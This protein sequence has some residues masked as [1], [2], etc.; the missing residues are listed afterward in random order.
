MGHSKWQILPK[1]SFC[2][3]WKEISINWVPIGDPN[4]HLIS[5]PQILIGDPKI[6][7]GGPIFSLR[8]QMFNG[9]AFYQ[10]PMTSQLSRIKIWWSPMNRLGSPMKI[11]GT[12]M[13]ILGTPMKILGLQ[14]RVCG[15]RLISWVPNENLGDSNENLGDSIKNLRP[16]VKSLGSPKKNLESSMKTGKFWGSPIKRL[17]SSLKIW[18]SPMRWLLWSPILL[19][20]CW[21]LPELYLT[22]IIK[23][24]RN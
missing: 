13:K 17:W 24:V 6:F 9:Q 10:K 18:G 11:L 7:I 14:W 4:S 5:D 3:V 21:F 15:L 2:Q 8:P 19:Q 16:P 22:F 12:P 1:Y 20:W 23:T